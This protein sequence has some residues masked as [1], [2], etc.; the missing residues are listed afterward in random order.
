MLQYFAVPHD[1]GA[2]QAKKLLFDPRQISAAEALEL[3]FVTEVVPAADL[4]RHTTELAHRIAEHSPFWLRMAKQA[5][6]G[7]QDAAGFRTAVTSAHA[8]YM[9]AQADERERLRRD[10]GLDPTPPLPPARRR[11]TVERILGDGGG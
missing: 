2:R 8:H 9:L 10:A 11:P 1:V 4:G 6:N 7:A 3:G 5:V